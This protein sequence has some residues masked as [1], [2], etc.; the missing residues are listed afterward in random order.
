MGRG[1]S[2]TDHEKGMIDIFVKDGHSQQEIAKKINR[3]MC[4]VNNYIKNKN[5]TPQ[6]IPGRPEKLS[7]RNKRAIIRDVRKSGKSVSQI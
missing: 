4:A 5:K 2:F 6:K 3:L 1:N 7:P